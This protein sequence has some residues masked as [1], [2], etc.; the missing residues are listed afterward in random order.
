MR[1]TIDADKVVH[2]LL[3]GDVAIQEAIA[4][5]FWPDVCRS[6]GQ[7]DRAALGSYRVRR[8]GGASGRLEALLHPATRL[9]IARR[10][11][12]ARPMWL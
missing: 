1:W 4:A 9:E 12:T 11:Q 2:E 8:P 5:E 3:A 7:I 10:V 6:D